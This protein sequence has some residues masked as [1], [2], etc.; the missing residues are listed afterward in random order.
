MRRFVWLIALVGCGDRD[1]PDAAPAMPSVSR[2]MELDAEDYGRARLGFRT[3]HERRGPSPQVGA[4]PR[5]PAGALKWTYRSAG[6]ELSAF[7][8]PDPGDGFRRPAVLFLHG[9]FAFGEGDW[10]MARPF[11]E[12]AYAVMVPLL[13]G[14]NGQPGDFSLF[15][16]EVDDVLAAAEALSRL[17]WVDPDRL[18]VAGHSAGGTLAMLAAMATDKFRA[19]ASFSGSPDQAMSTQDQ[20]ERTPFDRASIREVRMRSPVAFAS[21]FR[22]PARLYHGVEEFWAEGSTAMTASR[23]KAAGLDVEAVPVAGDHFSSVPGAIRRAIAFFG[24]R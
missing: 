13:R 14:E 3:K 22:C 16:D 17:P 10:A 7:A 18:F 1:E 19:A 5:T 12:A 24:R 15:H 6:R 20:P 8:T 23:A 4:F 11:R 2:G 9:G 21:S